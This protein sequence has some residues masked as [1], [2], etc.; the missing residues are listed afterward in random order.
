MGAENTNHDNR[1]DILN[2]IPPGAQVK[3]RSPNIGDGRELGDFWIDISRG[4]VWVCVAT[5]GN[6]RKWSRVSIRSVIKND[7]R[8]LKS[9]LR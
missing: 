5:L 6:A 4:N 3:N 8:I 9:G 7:K 1:R 2:N